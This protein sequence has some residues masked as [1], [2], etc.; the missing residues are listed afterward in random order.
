MVLTATQR[1]KA[2][3]TQHRPFGDHRVTALREAGGEE[4]RVEGV[5]DPEGQAGPMV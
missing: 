5:A 3:G 1:D 4:T 2:A